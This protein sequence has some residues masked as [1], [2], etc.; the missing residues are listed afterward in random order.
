MTLHIWFEEGRE[1]VG[2]AHRP[3][4]KRRHRP[5]IPL[6]CWRGTTP[7]RAVLVSLRSA[8]SGANQ[9]A[10]LKSTPP[11]NLAAQSRTAV[12]YSTMSCLRR[13]ARF[14]RGCEKSMS[15]S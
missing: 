14:R 2:S 15:I 13:E 7:V 11:T 5:E 6:S 1:V 9:G 12:V 4:A 8:A 3:S 10:S